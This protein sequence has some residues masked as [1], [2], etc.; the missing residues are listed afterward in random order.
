MTTRTFWDASAATGLAVVAAA[1]AVFGLLALAKPDHFDER[2]V[3][4]HD[5]S[6]L[7]KQ[8]AAKTSPPLFPP[9]ALCKLAP[10]A[11]AEKLNVD[12]RAAAQAA[13][14]K[15]MDVQVTPQAATDEDLLPLTVRVDASGDYESI[16]GLLQRLSSIRPL[17]FIDTVDL[18]SKTSF[19]TFTLSGRVLCQPLH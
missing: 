6:L 2:L 11:E 17:L 10:Q 19:V 3:A 9:D 15:Q 12:L 18:A 8:M 14:L 13:Q 16:L 1:A 7:A 4:I 5:Q